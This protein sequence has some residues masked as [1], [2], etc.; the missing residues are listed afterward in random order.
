MQLLLV[1]HSP[2]PRHNIGLKN[3]FCS[4]YEIFVN[5]QLTIQCN[6]LPPCEVPIFLSLC[7]TVIVQLLQKHIQFMRIAKSDN[8]PKR[9]SELSA[10]QCE[11]KTPL[12][13]ETVQ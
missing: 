2:T 3:L 9:K 7:I 12:G 11:L 13:T 1:A 4:R 8:A 10:R 6:L 5:Y